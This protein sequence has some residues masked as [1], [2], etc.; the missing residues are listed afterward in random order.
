MSKPIVNIAR[1]VLIDAPKFAIQ[2][3]CTNISVLSLYVNSIKMHNLRENY[4]H[5]SRTVSYDE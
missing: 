4:T 1:L 3:L 2:S 5:S